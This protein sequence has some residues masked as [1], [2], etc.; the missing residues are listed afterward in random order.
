MSSAVESDEIIRPV[1]PYVLTGPVVPGFQRGSKQL[2]IP[3]GA[4][5]PHAVSG[6]V[7]QY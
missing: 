7:D 4:I 6:S 1:G 2:G 5:V 3:T